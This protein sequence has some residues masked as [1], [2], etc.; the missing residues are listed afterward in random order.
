MKMR[1]ALVLVLGLCPVLMNA[2]SARNNQLD[3]ILKNIPADSI[4]K[5][6]RL[7]SVLFHEKINAYRLENHLT[8][9]AWDDTLWLTASN[10]NAWML[11][12]NSVEHL[13]TSGTKL[14]TGVTPGDRYD[15]A[16]RGK[17]RCMWS[18]EN[19]LNE[20]DAPFKTLAENA[21]HM[22]E[23]AFRL[24]ENSPEH[25][26]NMLNE[27]SRVHAVAFLIQSNGCVWA[28]DLFAQMP[29]YSPLVAKP[30]PV[31]GMVVKTGKVTTTQTTVIPTGDQKSGSQFAAGKRDDQ[32]FLPSRKKNAHKSILRKRK[33]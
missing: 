2:Q 20:Y 6:E 18:G 17:G 29:R 15:Y 10:H 22:A 7:A 8:A 33:K 31:P 16:T 32:G 25:N 4:H 30:A 5:T 14:F 9:L 11:A 26:E 21:E 24:W 27:S 12:N 28:T 13:E 19:V 1:K 3:G 23:K